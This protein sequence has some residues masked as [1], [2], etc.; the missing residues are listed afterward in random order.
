MLVRHHGVGHE[1]RSDQQPEHR[2]GRDLTIVARTS[3]RFPPV[4]VHALGWFGLAVAI[5]ALITVDIVGHVRKPHAP[6]LKESTWWSI[7]YVLLGLAF[8]LIIWG[9]Y[10]GQFAG[11][12]YAGFLT[13]KALS[14]DNLF[15]FII[16]MSSFRVPRNYQ[17][18]ALLSGIIIALVLRLVFILVGAALIERFTWVFFIFG[19]WLLWT[20]FSQAREGIAGEDEHEDEEYHENSFVKLMRR[21]FPVTDGFIGDKFLHR[22]GGRTYLTPMLLVVFALG[23]ADLMFAF[24]SIPAIFGLTHEPYLV[25]ASNAFALLGLRQLY[26]LI[27]RLL[28]RLV[29]LHYGLAA[30]LA[31]IGMKLIFHAMHENTLVFLNGGEGIHW[32]PE[33]GILPSLSFI[34]VTIVVT[35]V[36]SLLKSRSM[37]SK[38]APLDTH[39]LKKEKPA[40]TF[41]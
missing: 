23:T 3:E 5:L 22:H 18:K 31:F 6:T 19:A 34:I 36:T 24:D 25:F 13:E 9:V 20:A 17:Q 27:E 14:L 38:D 32:A 7:G 8:G 29:Y 4:H 26:F 15:V 1:H 37:A 39:A 33:I 21:V 2:V 35:V 10:G 11:E 12:Y 16:I 40:R 30:I 28:E 41:D